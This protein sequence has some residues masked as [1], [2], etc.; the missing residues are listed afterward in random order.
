LGCLKRVNQ[1]LEFSLNPYNCWIIE[2]TNAI[3]MRKM[4]KGIFGYFVCS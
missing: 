2:V 4:L 3:V 1:L